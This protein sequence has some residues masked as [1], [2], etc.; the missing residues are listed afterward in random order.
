MTDRAPL[1]LDQLVAYTIRRAS[2]G[3]DR[4]PLFTLTTTY[5]YGAQCYAL[6]RVGQYKYARSRDEI[7]LAPDLGERVAA[8]W[9]RSKYGAF[10]GARSLSAILKA[11]G[12]PDLRMHIAEAQRAENERV[13]EL[14]LQ[15][16]LRD[17]AEA[18]R[19]AIDAGAKLPAAALMFGTLTTL[20][21][22][23]NAMTRTNA[24]LAQLVAYTG[25]FGDRARADD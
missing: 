7:P 6:D 15:R 11:V 18:F 23:L 5:R 17:T 19:A 16:N 1:T 8:S 3:T 14:T 22:S 4:A 12:G 21:E 2:S 9:K 10:V 20:R 24:E 25:T 13:A